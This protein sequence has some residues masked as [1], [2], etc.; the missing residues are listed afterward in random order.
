MNFRKLVSRARKNESGAA[1]I[2]ALLLATV[3]LAMIATMT[4]VTVRSSEKSAA[5]KDNIYY[6]QAAD[7]AIANAVLSANQA[8]GLEFLESKGKATWQTSPQTT[9]FTTD[10]ITVYS[11]WYVNK[12]PSADGSMHYELYAAG[13][14]TAPTDADAVVL[15][16]R[17]EGLNISDT[18]IGDDGA[19]R[20]STDNPLTVM[21]QGFFATD[22]IKVATRGA[23]FYRYAPSAPVTPT[24]AS[25]NVS[26]NGYVHFPFSPNPSPFPIETLSFYNAPNLSE[27][28]L[29]PRCYG[30]TIGDGRC[31]AADVKAFQSAFNIKDLAPKVQQECSG[32]TPI[33]W[34]V[35]GTDAEGNVLNP[36]VPGKDI[37]CLSSLQVNGHLAAPSVYNAARPLTVYVTGDITVNAGS[38]L[39][40]LQVASP[41]Y[42]PDALRIIS[43]GTSINGTVSTDT[44]GLSQITAS[45][46]APNANC[47]MGSENARVVYRGSLACKTLTLTNSGT[48]LNF[49]PDT[50]TTANN[51]DATTKW[52]WRST[53]YENVGV[54]EA[55]SLFS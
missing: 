52:T 12:I 43:L 46:I 13:Y 5:T 40:P 24:G 25:S 3:L 6:S 29:G 47:F 42:T 4:A 51:G 27:D 7:A 23:G 26:T 2:I 54:A 30:T 41:T 21:R 50:L 8:G 18:D 20:Y 55:A 53:S 45:I 9:E 16:I 38:N 44:S 22:F 34:N 17:M 35:T 32:V 49:A 37:V 10:G 31:F 48:S 39:S 36:N 33:A 19:I 28:N 11:S 1:M 15:R 14:K